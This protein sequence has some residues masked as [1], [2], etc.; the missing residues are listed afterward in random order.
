MVLRFNAKES[1]FTLEDETEGERSIMTG[2]EPMGIERVT[3]FLSLFLS[4]SLS[5]CCLAN[6]VY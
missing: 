6:E 2:V 1:V 4:L 5:S 3:L